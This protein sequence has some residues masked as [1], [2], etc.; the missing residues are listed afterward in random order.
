MAERREL[1]TSGAKVRKRHRT[2]VGTKW[3]KKQTLW[4]F[5]SVLLLSGDI[6]TNPGPVQRPC[7]ACVACSSPVTTLGIQC[8]LCDGWCHPGCANVDS[9]K[10]ERLGGCDD[11][12]QCPKCCMPFFSSSLFDLSSQSSEESIR[13]VTR[14]LHLNARSVVNKRLEVMAR[15]DHPV[16]ETFL[17]DDIL[18]AEIISDGFQVYRRDQNRN[19]GRILVAVRNSIPSM[20][21]MDLET[22]G[23]VL[24]VQLSLPQI[25][26]LLIGTFYH[27]PSSTTMYIAELANSL[28]Q[29]PLTTPVILCGDFNAGDI[30]WDILNPSSSSPVSRALCDIL[31][32]NSLE[33]LVKIPTHNQNILDLL[34]LLLTNQTKII[35]D[36]EVVDGLNFSSRATAGQKVL[37][38]WKQET[39]KWLEPVSLVADLSSRIFFFLD[40]LST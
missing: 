20:R 29:I 35:Q 26:N 23:E 30:D 6:Q 15:L 8:D 11:S 3:R 7:V 34:D 14:G 22:D 32:D 25:P 33:Q 37:C 39:G 17:S 24:W 19:G 12:W 5:A 31:Q 21:R 40:A 27:P 1:V 18:D 10:Y 13:T 28:A 4:L 9:L 38:F 16:T 2:P 36:L